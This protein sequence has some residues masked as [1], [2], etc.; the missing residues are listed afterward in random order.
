MRRT[1]HQTEGAERVLSPAAGR[2]FPSPSLIATALTKRCSRKVQL[3]HGFPIPPF[4]RL[5]P[6][7]QSRLYPRLRLK[8]PAAR[9]AMAV[10]IRFRARSGR[11]NIRTRAV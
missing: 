4:S 6:N 8:Q 2:L 10:Q 11:S 5:L 7:L 3:N 9:L 1:G